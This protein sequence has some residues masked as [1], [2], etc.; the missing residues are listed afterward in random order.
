M[1][2]SII[3]AIQDDVAE[4]TDML[5]YFKDLKQKVDLVKLIQDDLG[6]A[7]EMVAEI[8][9]DHYEV[10]DGQ[11]IK[12]CFEDIS[13]DEFSRIVAENEDD[14]DVWVNLYYGE[15]ELSMTFDEYCFILKSIYE[16]AEDEIIELFEDDD[17]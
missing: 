13:D 5:E 10:F 3:K 12:N 6:I 16:R 11:W 9:G 1:L 15:K 4:S 8:N 2:N 14:C 17:E 7:M